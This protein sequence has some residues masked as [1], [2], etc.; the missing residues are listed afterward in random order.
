MSHNQLQILPSEVG[1]W[2]SLREIYLANNLL[3]NLPP[4]NVRDKCCDFN[5]ADIAC[6]FVNKLQNENM[7]LKDTVKK[8]KDTVKKLKEKNKHLKYAYGGEGFQNAMDDYYF[9]SEI[10]N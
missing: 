7:E 4:E 5:L 10:K 3:Q 1:Q 8:L 2:T 9:T 6:N